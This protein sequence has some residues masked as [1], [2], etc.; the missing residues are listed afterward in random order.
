[1][2]RLTL[3]RGVGDVRA[4]RAAQGNASVLAGVTMISWTEQSGGGTRR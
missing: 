1:M 3:Y 2:L 4:L